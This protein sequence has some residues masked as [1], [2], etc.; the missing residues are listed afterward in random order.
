MPHAHSAPS[1]SNLEAARGKVRWGWRILIAGAVLAAY[2]G[3]FGVPFLFDDIAAVTQNPSLQRLGDAFNPPPD[4]SVSGRPLVNF[5]LALNYAAGGSA[6]AGYHAVNLALHLANALLIFGLVR[7]AAPR[8]RLAVGCETLAGA[9]SL[10]WGLHP[11]ATS[12]VTYVMQRTELLVS[13]GAIS[14][15]YAFVRGSDPEA[16]TARARLWL[17]LS[18]FA[19]FAAMAAKEVAVV[20]PLLVLLADRTLNGPIRL[21]ALLRR[22]AGFYPA[23]AGSWLLLVGLL[24]LTPGR[25][26][27]AG[28]NSGVT[29]DDYALSQLAAFVTYIQLILWPTPL[30]F[31]RG[32]TL[33]PIG[34]ATFC[35]GVMLILLLA[36]AIAS[37]WRRP[38]VAAASL[39]FLLLL[40]PSSSVVPIA[41]QIL[42]EHRL[43]LASCGLLLL[44]TATALHALGPR[45]LIIAALAL[46]APFLVLT[47][48][49]N[50]D[51][52]TLESIWADTALKAPTN[53]RAHFNYGLALEAA[54]KN[55]QARAAYAACLARDALHAE[56]HAHLSRLLQQAGRHAEAVPH[57]ES[58][59]RLKSDFALHNAAA[60]SLLMLGETAAAIRHFE[61]SLQLR[62]D[63]PLVHY[64]LGLAL[65]RLRQYPAALHHF[66]AA[67]RL[68][69]NDADSARAAAQLRDFLRP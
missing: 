11:L 45:R 19:C 7:R 10:L 66:E 4:L 38:V 58:A 44:A 3:T 67:A 63:Q 33:I 60:V 40:A 24:V 9:T 27:S 41:T 2:A 37:W 55:D 29:W 23:L 6:V 47:V 8:L 50:R 28:L 57:F 15:V 49:R 1:N 32:A 69:P 51:Y 22:R 21:G 56:A 12:S 65:Q 61:D 26:A 64:N 30:V 31:D 13:L 20:I 5:S 17:I 36:A 16:K 34:A 35:G 68:A 46:A 14:A 25:G 43:Y 62:A 18:V 52:A 48:Q 53:A 42:G 59:L 54:G 39:W